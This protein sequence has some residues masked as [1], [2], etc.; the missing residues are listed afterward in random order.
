MPVRVD[1][2]DESKTILLWQFTGRWTTNELL[3]VYDE[4]CRLCDTVPDRWVYAI[5]DMRETSTLPNLISSSVS[6]RAARD[7][8]N[9]AGAF[10]VTNNGFFQA[11]VNILNHIGASKGKFHIASSIEAAQEAIAERRKTLM[12]LSEMTEQ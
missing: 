2:F 10:V 9:Y 12:P 5:A 6:R 1:W 8:K 11:I 3:E 7:P 4:G